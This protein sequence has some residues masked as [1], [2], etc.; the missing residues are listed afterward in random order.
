VK[1]EF[2]SGAPCEDSMILLED[3]GNHSG[4]IS[5]NEA[6]FGLDFSKTGGKEFA[7]EYS[8]ISGLIEGKKLPIPLLL[9]DNFK[10]EQLPWILKTKITPIDA[11]KTLQSN[12]P[13]VEFSRSGYLIYCSERIQLV[14][15]CIPNGMRG[16]GGH[17]HNDKLSF[18]LM[19]DQIEIAVDP[20]TYLYTPVP[21]LRNH[22][23]SAAV[24][25]CPQGEKYSQNSWRP[26][27]GGLFHL[28]DD[29]V[30][31][32]V[33]V[34]EHSILLKMAMGEL[35]HLREFRINVG[36]IE[37]IDYSTHQ[38][39]FTLPEEQTISRTYGQLERWKM[40]ENI[41]QITQKWIAQP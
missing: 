10:K 25:T 2:L 32:I 40:P 7:L 1:E 37:I 14:A 34:N 24:H 17:N 15:N 31:E 26:G 4:V 35:F 28:F 27:R 9:R 11:T 22:Y 19:L 13:W 5:I 38:F 8:L 36:E 39:D 23:R 12:T 18:T 33:S 16:Y 41:C 30:V 3:T 6:M 20:G 21:S 29:C